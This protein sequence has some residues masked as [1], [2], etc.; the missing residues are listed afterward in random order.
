MAS[1]C[2]NWLQTICDARSG[3]YRRIRF[4]SAQTLA[5]N[6]A[7]G[8][9][10]ATPA[11][12]RHAAELAGLESD[13]AAFPQGYDTIVGER[14]ILLSG[15][16]KQR[17]AIARAIVK[18]PRILIFDD[19]LSSVDSITEHRILDHLEASIGDRTTMLIS[20]RLST[21]RRADHIIV[22][23]GGRVAESGSHQQLL[24]AGGYYAGLWREQLLATELET[25]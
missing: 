22:L 19:A 10:E 7:L 14:G 25:A 3:S 9:P 12:I 4:C 17:V 24:D 15:G 23:D 21:V 8:A 18:N 13:I 2:A 1:T 20:H 5:Q 11:E 16:Q 6:I